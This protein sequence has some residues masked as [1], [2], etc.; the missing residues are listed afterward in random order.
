MSD[1]DMLEVMEAMAGKVERIEAQ[2]QTIHAALA[3]LT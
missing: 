1:D 3:T 2:L